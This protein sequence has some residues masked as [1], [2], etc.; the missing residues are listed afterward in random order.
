MKRRTLQI[1]LGSIAAVTLSTGV[2]ALSGYLPLVL[3]G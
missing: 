2:M 3:G 1:V